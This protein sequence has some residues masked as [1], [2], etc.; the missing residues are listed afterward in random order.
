MFSPDNFA[1][2]VIICTCGSF[3]LSASMVEGS[4]RRKVLHGENRRTGGHRCWL[5]LALSAK[6]RG[7]LRAGACKKGNDKEF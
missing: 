5:Y 1:P 6:F 7:G 3:V 4:Y 2:G